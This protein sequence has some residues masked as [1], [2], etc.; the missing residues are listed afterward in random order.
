MPRNFKLV[1]SVAKTSALLRCVN[2]LSVAT[3]DVLLQKLTRC[4]YQQTV[5]AKLAIGEEMKSLRE[6][7]LVVNIVQKYNIFVSSQEFA[8]SKKCTSVYR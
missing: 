8:L 2:K 3:I 1:K 4:W 6:L 7:E 5:L